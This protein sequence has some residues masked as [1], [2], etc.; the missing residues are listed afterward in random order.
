[1]G[2]GDITSAAV[3]TGSGWAVEIKRPLKTE[4]AL[5]QDV[6]FSTL[7]NQQF[8]VAIW[9]ASNYQHGIQPNLVLKFK[10]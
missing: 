5:K 6:D 10:K 7:E 4:D 1:N 9:N 3:Y 8:G 2:R